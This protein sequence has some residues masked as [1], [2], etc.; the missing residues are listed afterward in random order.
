LSASISAPK[1]GHKQAHPRVAYSVEEAAQMC[2]LAAKT[3]RL[4]VRSGELRAKRLSERP[5]GRGVIR[6]TPAALQAWLEG[7]ES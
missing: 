3:I 6:I 1:R 5:D 4:A 2:G 7:G